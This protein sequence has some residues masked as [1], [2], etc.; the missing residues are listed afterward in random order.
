MTAGKQRDEF[1]EW[2]DA[3]FDEQISE[4]NRK[5]LEDWIS[6]CPRNADHFARRACQHRQLFEISRERDV[7]RFMRGVEGEVPAPKSSLSGVDQLN[8][9]FRIFSWRSLSFAGALAAML[10]VWFIVGSSNDQ[11]SHQF[12]DGRA[13]LDPVDEVLEKVLGI[14]GDHVTSSGIATLSG[15]VDCRWKVG[16]NPVSYGQSLEP[17]DEIR[18]ESGI[19]QITF[20]SGAKLLVTGPSDF[21]VDEAMQGTLNLGKLSA[22]VPRRA[23]G[24]VVKTPSSN[25]VDL[26]TEFGIVV[27]EEGKSEVHVFEGE[28]IAR[29]LDIEGNLHGDAMHLTGNMAAR[30]DSRNMVTETFAAIESKFIRR[31]RPQL[32]ID[33]LPPLAATSD[34]ALW[35]AADVSV[36]LDDSG[37][38]MAW[39]DILCGDN[40]SE[41]DAL[42][43]T[44]EDRPLWV[45]DALHGMPALRFDGKTSHLVTTSMETS[46]DQT[47]FLVFQFHE[48]NQERPIGGQLINYNGPPIRY[49]NSFTE[50]GILQIGDA[51]EKAKYPHSFDA[52]VH[53]GRRAESLINVGHTSVELSE[54][55]NYPILAN[56]IYSN[57][58][59]EAVLRINGRVVSE[60]SAPVPIAIASRKVIGRHAHIAKQA[61]F[62][63]IAEI[64]IYN[65]VLAEEQIREVEDYLREKYSLSIT[66]K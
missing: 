59:N 63:D 35:L 58:E 44:E 30:Y 52:L 32:A 1:D 5:K 16:A 22:V 50:P 19:V 7:Q 13:V 37:R 4:H 46:N 39:R 54:E 11:G 55:R 24:F 3:L 6:D 26:G 31:I 42:Q 10:L 56:Y 8:R 9:N 23:S 43:P 29:A 33:Q 41:D 53:A 18:L 12:S 28:V 61:F 57:T 27:D 34:L 21:V 15:T 38:V 17:G 14:E 51:R 47:L 20:E 65:S 62:G 45:K 40:Q 66:V 60:A 2:I 36:K 49:F 48:D 64:L 25:I